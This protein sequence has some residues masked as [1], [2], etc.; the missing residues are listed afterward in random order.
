MEN[1][2]GKTERT[3]EPALNTNRTFFRTRRSTPMNADLERESA[4]IRIHRRFQLHR[5][6]MFCDVSILEVC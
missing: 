4:L 3:R 2:K 5:A 6:L 1:V